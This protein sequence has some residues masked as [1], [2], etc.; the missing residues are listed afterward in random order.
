[1]FRFACF[2]P[3]VSGLLGLVLS[4]EAPACG[5]RLADVPTLALHPNPGQ[6]LPPNQT[7]KLFGVT[8][9]PMSGPIIETVDNQN[10]SD[11]DTSAFALL[12]G[13]HVV[14]TSK[15]LVM[16]NEYVTWRGALSSRVFA[17]NMKGGHTYVVRLL[18]RQDMSGGGQVVFHGEEQ[19]AKGNRTADFDPV[20]SLDEIKACMNANR[21]GQ[22]ARGD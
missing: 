10:V 22:G 19:D 21:G 9:A 16:G 6:P 1:M 7:A 17:F 20:S 18:I 4:V 13:C 15:N 12:P 3:V 5:S 2:H 14:I 11:K 8:D